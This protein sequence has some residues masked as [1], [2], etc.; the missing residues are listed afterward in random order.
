M[1]WVILFVE[2]TIYYLSLLCGIFF[3]DIL[4]EWDLLKISSTNQIK[5]LIIST[6]LLDSTLH[7]IFLP[8]CF[9]GWV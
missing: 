6:L 9:T 1:T 2:I 3:D 8:L 4:N 5:E 7:N